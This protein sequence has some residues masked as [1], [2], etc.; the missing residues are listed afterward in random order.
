M[1]RE[2]SLLTQPRAVI[3][4]ASDKDARRTS[5]HCV[6]TTRPLRRALQPFDSSTRTKIFLSRGPSN[7][8]KKTPCQVPSTNLPSSTKITWL[9]PTITALA[10][11]SVLPPPPAPQGGEP[12]FPP[13]FR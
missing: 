9:P 5:T 3:L 4:R 6:F 11:E 12:L 8:Q 10:C 1:R 13:A 2:T 7:S